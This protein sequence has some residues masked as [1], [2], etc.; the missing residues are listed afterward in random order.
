VTFCFTLRF[1]WV[2]QTPQKG[3]KYI[4][5]IRSRGS[6]APSSSRGGDLITTP[7]S[8]FVSVPGLPDRIFSD[9]KFQFVYILE[10]FGMENV[11]I[12][13]G[14]LEYFTAIWCNL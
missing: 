6:L 4:L 11:G 9:Q 13:Y 1:A 10:C 7:L 8:I 2:A 3:R 5:R 12:F 14:N